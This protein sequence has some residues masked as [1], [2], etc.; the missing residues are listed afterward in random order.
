MKTV[1]Y[2]H[3]DQDY[4]PIEDYYNGNIGSVTEI[5]VIPIQSPDVPINLVTTP[6]FKSFSVTWEKHIQAR[7]FDI[8]YQMCIR[9]SLYSD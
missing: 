2:T 7:D 4:N 5:Q 6:G 1:S 9:D 8:Y 3:L